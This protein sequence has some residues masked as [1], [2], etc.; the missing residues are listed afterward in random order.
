MAERY[1]REK[2]HKNLVKI[3]WIGSLFQTEWSGKLSLMM[4]TR[5]TFC[6]ATVIFK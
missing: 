1:K 5:E 2:T 4:V 3:I 6:E